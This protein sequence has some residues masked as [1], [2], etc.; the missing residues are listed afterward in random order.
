MNFGVIFLVGRT[1]TRAQVPDTFR[2]EGPKQPDRSIRIPTDD[3][4]FLYLQPDSIPYA[5]LAVLGSILLTTMLVVRR[6]FGKTGRGAGGG[7]HLAMFLLG[8]GFMLLET[9]MVTALSL[10]FGSTWIVNASV[11]G[12]V[13]LVVLLANVLVTVR[14]P[15]RFTPWFVCLLVSLVGL[16]ALD[17]D[18]LN[19]LPLAARATLGGLLYAVPIGF[20]AVV[21]AVLFKRLANPSA[22]LA[23]NLVGALAGG[24]L[25]YLSMV[26]GLRALLLLAFAVYAAAWLAIRRGSTNLPLVPDVPLVPDS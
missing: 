16:Y 13:L 2:G 8:I 12:G 26:F 10:L 6:V 14:T 20:A 24:M 23:S 25:E 17:L 9:R 11:F 5:Y 15:S 21:F 1:L 4:P 18:T 3:W 19:Q 22:G 7:F